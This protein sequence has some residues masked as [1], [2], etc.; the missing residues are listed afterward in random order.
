MDEAPR[1]PARCNDCKCGLASG[2]ACQPMA[3]G[4]CAALQQRPR[5]VQEQSFASEFLT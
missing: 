2:D 4:L 5:R 1:V 3:S